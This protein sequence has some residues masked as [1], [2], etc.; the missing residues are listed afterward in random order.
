[1]HRDADREA[2][3]DAES[4]TEYV[5]TARAGLRRQAFLLCGDWHEADDLVQDTLT[6]MYRRWPDVSRRGEMEGYA[7]TA[8]VRRF[9]SVRRQMRWRRETPHP[10]PPDRPRTHDHAA[11]DRISMLACLR[12]LP[13]RQRAVIVLR[14]WEDLSIQ[15]TAEALGVS[16]GTVASQHHRA[17]TT[18]RQS[19]ADL[20]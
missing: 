5:L 15:Q 19:L 1:M 4:F 2:G 8:L 9:L 14:F 17:L 13:P 12:R 7:H 10:A 16:P 6:N 3:S 11:D 18:L 20:R